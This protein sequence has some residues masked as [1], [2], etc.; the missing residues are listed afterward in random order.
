MTRTRTMA[1]AVAMAASLVACDSLLAGG[2]DG[3][4]LV[5][6]DAEFG[7]RHDH[8]KAGVPYSFDDVVLCLDEAGEVSVESVELANPTGGLA[9]LGFSVRREYPGSRLNYIEN[10]EGTTLEREGFPNHGP[11][12]VGGICPSL[13]E[14]ETQAED[15][16]SLLGVELARSDASTD[17]PAYGTGFLIHYRSE[18]DRRSVFVG[19]SVVLCPEGGGRRRP[20]C[21]I[22]EIRPPD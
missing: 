10:P 22:T 16:M 8:V 2:G 4:R 18:D 1:A 19:F 14:P 3:P 12:V 9:L 15:S 13:Q 7:V 21:D 20:D 6:P 17:E 11:F 5:V